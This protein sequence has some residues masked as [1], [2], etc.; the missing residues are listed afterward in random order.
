MG[1]SGRVRDAV[2]H[3][4]RKARERAGYALLPHGI[5]LLLTDAC[6]LSCKYCPVTNDMV[7]GRATGSTDTEEAIRF[8][9]SVARF[10][11]EIRFF[12]GEPFLHPEWKRIFSAAVDCGLSITVVTNGTRLLG[13]ARELVKSGLLAI[14]I[15]VDPPAAHDAFRGAGTFSVCERVVQEI[16]RA[17]AELGSPTPS[18]VVYTTV[19]EATYAALTSWAEQLKDWKIDMLRLQ[20]QIWL[21]SARRLSSERL[22]AGAIGDS[23][24]FRS[25]VDTYCTDT[26]PNV[27][28]TILESQLRGLQAGSY[29]F[30][31]EHHPPLS[32][33]EM[34]TFYRSPDFERQTARACS[35]IREYAFVDPRGRLYPCLTLDMGNV[36]EQPFERVWNGSRF[37]AFRR[38]V[39]KE[40]RLPLC[41]R[42]P[43]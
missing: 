23:T 9:R 21:G 13:R 5:D 26:M 43:A 6:N 12:G 33:E 20:H 30:P 27:D 42:C 34:L 2:R 36:F 11:P 16:Q 41:A 19:Y 18:I 38:L 37:R 3:V 25:D 28:L 24:F 8:L 31:V 32:V 29:N 17:R 14:G 7:T 15:S 22:I 39:R 40:Q 1:T 4:V 35:L 10:R